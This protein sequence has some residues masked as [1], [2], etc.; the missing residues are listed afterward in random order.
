MRILAI[1]LILFMIIPTCI[2]AEFQDGLESAVSSAKSKLDVPEHYTNFYSQIEQTDNGKIFLLSWSGEG[3]DDKEGGYVSVKVDQKGRIVYYSQYDYG[4]LEGDYKLSQLDYKGAVAIAEQHI[5]KLCPDFAFNVKVSDYKNYIERNYNS[6]YIHFYRH[7]YSIPYYS[8]YIVAAVNARSGKLSELVVRWDDIERFPNSQGFMQA[9]RAKELFKDKIGV[10]LGYYNNYDNNVVLMYKANVTG[11]EYIN[12]FTGELTQTRISGGIFAVDTAYFEKNFRY[13][14]RDNVIGEKDRLIPVALLEQHAREQLQI[15]DSYSL[16]NSNL[17][18]DSNGFY[19]NILLASE[20][21]DTINVQINAETKEITGYSKSADID[22][23]S[24]VSEDFAFKSAKAFVQKVTP[25]FSS[26]TQTHNPYIKIQRDGYNFTFVFSR[27]VNGL[28]YADNGIAVNVSASTGEVIS[29][30]SNWQQMVFPSPSTDITEQDVFNELF[31]R[32]GFELQYIAVAKPG[33]IYPERVRD[34][35][36]RLVYNFVPGK[37]LF[38]SASNGR[39]CDVNGIAYTNDL[40]TKYG[41]TEGHPSQQIIE[42]LRSSNVLNGNENFYPNDNITQLDYLSMIYRAINQ[43]VS[44]DSDSLYRELFNKNVI[45]ETERDDKAEIT[46]EYAVK[47]LIRLLGYTDVAELNDTYRTRFVDEG[48]INP[49][50]I[51]YAAISQGLRIVRGNAFTPK[52]PVT[53][54]TAAEIIY[55]LLVPN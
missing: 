30:S 49:E 34:I 27:V 46:F 16:V 13:A 12:A 54:A 4:D 38:V 24:S 8:N 6:Y 26:F 41:D 18:S 25:N 52:R 40:D 14:Q 9:E 55:N 22:E 5:K 43:G 19:Y 50:Y 20:E 45:T 51:G 33:I 23:Y 17:L 39:L 35:D 42:T 15:N 31:E 11:R 1:I 44:L 37:P 32:V 3:T 29:Y 36:I 47:Y 10:S 21:Q 7:Q 2:S 53:R 28:V 48:A